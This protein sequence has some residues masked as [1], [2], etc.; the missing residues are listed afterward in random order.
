MV[1]S[2][3][4]SLSCLLC[5]I[6]CLLLVSGLALAKE[7]PQVLVPVTLMEEA[8]DVASELKLT[9]AKLMENNSLSTKQQEA[10]SKLMAAPVARKLLIV[11]DARA[12]ALKKKKAVPSFGKISGAE[13][14]E[15]DPLMEWGN[16]LLIQLRGVE[17][18][19]EEESDSLG[20]YDNP[21][22]MRKLQESLEMVQKA[23]EAAS[24]VQKKAA[25]ANERIIENL[26]G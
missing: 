1:R 15:I 10:L 14:L 16:Y 17:E 21:M 12:S 7:H 9:I 24:K 2:L 6:L 25:E 3:S 23:L 13:Q 11:G 20:N 19:L 4:L 22:K 5:S 18:S 8:G 26:K